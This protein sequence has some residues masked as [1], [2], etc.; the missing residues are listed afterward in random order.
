[1]ITLIS[2]DFK[3]LS[4]PESLAFALNMHT[5]MNGNPKFASIQTPLLDTELPEA[6]KRFEQLLHESADGS[7]TKILERKATRLDVQNLVI[8]TATHVGIISNGNLALIQ[9][10]GFNLRNQVIRRFTAGIDQVTGLRAKQGR[11]PGE[12]IVTYNPVAGAHM[13]AIEWS[14]DN[15]LT[16]QNGV[17]SSARRASVTGLPVRQDILFRVYALGAQQR[18]GA[19]SGTVSVFLL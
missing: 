7:K 19:V 9:E 5:R 12:A 6:L 14:L 8:K 11:Q 17:Y 4:D 16:W 3:T 10:A 13:Y 18:K 15:G 2:L 1:M